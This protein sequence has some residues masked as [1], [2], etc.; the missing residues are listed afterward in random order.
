MSKTQSSLLLCFGLLFSLP[1]AVV[2]GETG[3]CLLLKLNGAET[4]SVSLDKIPQY[5]VAG[6][7]LY[8]KTPEDIQKYEIGSVKEIVFQDSGLSRSETFASEGLSVYPTLTTDYVFV[9]GKMGGNIRITSA[10]GKT[11]AV[12]AEKSGDAIQLNVA[13]YPTGVY[14]VSCDGKSYKIIKG[15]L[16]K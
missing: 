16:V 15:Q 6:N 13:D 8:L 5:W 2:G 14:Y 10:D 11:M 4:V 7:S 1:L 9:S 12:R 3:K